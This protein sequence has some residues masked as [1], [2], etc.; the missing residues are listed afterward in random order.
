MATQE[1]CTSNVTI[2][3]TEL[4]SG[5]TYANLDQC[6]DLLAIHLEETASE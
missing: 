4:Q 3:P 1:V 5:G 2:T 6:A